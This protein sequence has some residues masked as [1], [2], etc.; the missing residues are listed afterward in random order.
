MALKF[1]H[2]ILIVDDEESV[3]KSMLR[4]FRH[5]NYDISIATSGMEGLS[6]IRDSKKPFSLIISDQRMPEMTGAQFL[7]EAQ[8]LLP[9]T[10]RVLLTGYSDIDAIVDAINDGGIHRYL[11]KPWKDEDLLLQVHQILEQY[12]LIIENRRL[13]ELTKR[14]SKALLS[15]NKNLEEKVR[16]K[17]GEIIKGEKALQESLR[18]LEEAFES[19]IEAF[20]T[21]V[22]VKDNYTCDHQKNVAKIACKISDE[23]GLSYDQRRAIRMSAIVHDIGKIALPSD[24]LSKPGKLSTMEL[25]MIRMHPEIGFRILKKI[26]FPCPVAQIVLQHHERMNGSGYPSGIS[27]GEIVL[28]ARILSVADVVDAMASHRPYRPA[29]GANEALREITNNRGILYDPEVVNACIRHLR[30]EDYWCE[31]SR[32]AAQI[33]T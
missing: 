10:M 14:Q 15:L 22:E 9:D 27:G 30:R 7:A 21:I 12:E 31:R 24:I 26:A 4:L 13:L 33:Q 29:L 23:M 17:T 6:R 18:R 3:M 8:K 28:E 32:H 11:T 25:G 19:A 20:S 16:K 5:E 2:A 1:N